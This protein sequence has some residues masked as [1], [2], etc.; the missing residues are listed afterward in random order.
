MEKSVVFPSNLLETSR[1][2]LKMILTFILKIPNNGSKLHKKD[3]HEM[4]FH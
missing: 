1:A 4:K 2:S 3:T